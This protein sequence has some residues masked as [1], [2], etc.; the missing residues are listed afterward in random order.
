MQ[1]G[2]ERNINII[3]LDV[4]GLGL[5]SQEAPHF[6]ND[7]VH[8][9]LDVGAP[10][11]FPPRWSRTTITYLQVRSDRR[12]SKWESNGGPTDRT[13]M[14]YTLGAL[15]CLRLST[16]CCLYAHCSVAVEFLP[17]VFV[18]LPCSACNLLGPLY[19]DFPPRVLC[20]L[21][22]AP[23]S[24]VSEASSSVDSTGFRTG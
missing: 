18:V 23:S 1:M 2:R 16:D 22:L 13:N 4:W 9:R 17:L 6:C 8:D 15:R 11:Q 12:K 21:Q 3:Y 19:R 10:G 14:Q 24:S 20:E 7:T 5:W